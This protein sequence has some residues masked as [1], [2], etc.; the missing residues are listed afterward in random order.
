MKVFIALLAIFAVCLGHEE[1]DRNELYDLVRGLLVGIY[2]NNNMDNLITCLHGG[3]DIVHKIGEALQYLQHPHE[4]NIEIGL[5][6]LFAA[7]T[8]LLDILKPCMATYPRLALLAVRLINPHIGAIITRILK[9]PGE[10][11]H[12]AFEA[13]HCYRAQTYFCLGKSVGDLMRFTLLA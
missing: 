8:R 4:H 9:H 10:F 6:L 1:P 3:E 2:E 11:F 12:D 7:M 5:N 13:L